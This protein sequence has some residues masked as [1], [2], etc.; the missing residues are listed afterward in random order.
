MMLRRY[1]LLLLLALV[2]GCAAP[3][4]EGPDLSETIEAYQRGPTADVPID[5]IADAVVAWLDRRGLSDALIGSG[6]VFEVIKT[7]V[8]RRLQNYG[9]TND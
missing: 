9:R 8:G 7:G 4:P 6:F 5:E 3:L 2:G 1:R